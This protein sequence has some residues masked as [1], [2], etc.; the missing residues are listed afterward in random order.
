MSLKRNR[1]E[2]GG[3]EIQLRRLVRE[4]IRNRRYQVGL[5]VREVAQ[6]VTEAA[7]SAGYQK[8]SKVS[9]AFLSRIEG[10]NWNDTPNLDHLNLLAQVLG[11]LPQD[12][13]MEGRFPREVTAE[14][15]LR[16]AGARLR[17]GLPIRRR[18]RRAISR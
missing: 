12:F 13:F 8:D 10:P 17:S 4:N 14:E 5:S 2:N 1:P 11:C 7:I 6:R 18:P 15:D 16:Q 9:A 3:R